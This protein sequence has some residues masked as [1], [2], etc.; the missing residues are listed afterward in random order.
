MARKFVA[1]N[2]PVH[3]LIRGI[4]RHWRLGPSVL[5]GGM[6]VFEYLICEP[7]LPEA[8]YALARFHTLEGM[9]LESFVPE[10]W[11]VQAR[12]KVG[13]P[14]QVNFFDVIKLDRR[15]AR[16]LRLKLSKRGPGMLAAELLCFGT[17]ALRARNDDPL[18]RVHRY[19]WSQH[20]RIWSE[21]ETVHTT[22]RALHWNSLPL[23]YNKQKE[24][25]D[26]TN[27]IY[28]DALGEVEQ[29]WE[30]RADIAFLD[31]VAGSLQRMAHEPEVAGYLY[32]PLNL[33]L[34][35]KLHLRC[36]AVWKSPPANGR[37]LLRRIEYVLS[38]TVVDDAPPTLFRYRAT[39]SQ[40]EA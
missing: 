27:V 17:G 26:S 30:R 29:L 23:K 24:S 5:P 40:K 10:R 33:G 38:N 21:H 15:C 36:Q 39:Q 11:R 13:L 34:V 9:S 2:D 1:I 37:A 31:Q 20:G 18:D 32:P 12:H 4:T 19:L 22:I 25:F 6:R 35:M 16:D 3:R 8:Y 14:Q 28:G 7:A